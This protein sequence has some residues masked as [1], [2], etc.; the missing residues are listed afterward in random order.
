MSVSVNGY[1]QH[2]VSYYT[3]EDVLSGRLRCPSTVPELASLE[4]SP[5]YLHKQNFRFPPMIDIGPDGIPRYR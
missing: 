1:A 5:D 4:I 2:M 3:I